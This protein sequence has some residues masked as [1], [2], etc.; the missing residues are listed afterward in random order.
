M[1]P[2]LALAGLE[3]ALRLAEYGYPTDFFLRSQINGRD[4]YVTNRKFGYRFFP[5]ALA[6]EASP[7]RMVAKKPANSYRIF[8]FGESAARGDPD[9]TYGVGRYLEVL[10]R[11]RFP[12]TRFE[13]VCVAVT[14]INSHAILPIARECTR[15]QPDLWV[16][17]MGNNEMIGP[18][19]PGTILGAK[20]PNLA[21]VRANLAL[22]TT[23]VG[24]LIDASM[25]RLWSNPSL[26][27]WG[28]MQMFMNSRL[29]YDNPLRLRAYEHLK[30]NLDDILVAGRRAGVPI[31]LSTMAVNLKDCGPFAS[32]HPATFDESQ[33]S[34]W[35]KAYQQGIA[36]ESTGSYQAALDHYA[37]AV[38]ID[39]QFADLQFRVGTCQLALTNYPQ[40]R[41][42]FELARDYD[43]LAIRADTRINQIIKDAAARYDGKGVYF[44]DGA[45]AL[46][47]RSPAGIPGE[48]LL[49]EHVHLNL[50]G[51]Y[52]L[53]RTFAEQV[54]KL[55]PHSVTVGNTGR[56]ASADLCDRRLA[57]TIWDRFRLWQII[58]NRLR[59]PP[60]PGQSNHATLIKVHDSKLDDIKSLMKTQTPNQAR[61]MYQQA[62][63]LNPEDN[64][65]RANFAQFLEAGGYLTQAIDEAQ[66]A[67]ELIPQ[68]A[69][70]YYYI[71]TLLVRA[72]KTGE[73][74]D[75]FSRALAIR[76]NFA[77]ALSE[78]G[79]VRA[80][81]QKTAEATACFNRALRADPTYVDA[82][83]D[84]GF[85]EQRQGRLDEAMAHYQEAARLQ[86]GGPADFFS[87]AVA[88]A[89]QGRS[90]EAIEYF[91]ALT[92]YAPEF[93]QARYLLG[94]ELSTQG[95]FEEAQS[96]FLET[97]RYRP[98]FASA[99]LNL[100][101]ILA[102]Q[103]KFDQALM[104]FRKTLQL[105]PTNKLAQQHIETMRARNQ[106]R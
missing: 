38:Q 99:H 27:K 46:A 51:N 66:R 93:W 53:A 12:G 45:E 26:K 94:V 9:P 2:L 16:I 20:A 91:R 5:P 84:L 58:R 30:R 36:L 74:A 76:S 10:L 6:R 28:G 62:L 18:F 52:L 83:L 21:F 56:W 47:Q 4:F 98:D 80:N 85:L 90:S 100:G 55:L 92:P 41:Q 37:Q 87:Q 86:P 61:E 96:Q 22:K 88:L 68:M 54:A 69:G 8:L 3:L 72:G 71:G 14:A 25:R 104:E 15:Y 1:V 81:Q 79:L 67:C 106:A 19:G 17:Y 33:Q 31:I 78:L 77:Q 64:L 73:A 13:V 105:D 101:I 49:Y 102:K 89:A 65:L 35:E 23:R 59:E 39:P 63:A 95:K 50:E 32:L 29:R 11:E 42:H 97:L 82:Y 24:Q 75:Y 70:P 34:N 103:A 48:E 7:L 40:A 60:Y 44:V 43:A 57:V